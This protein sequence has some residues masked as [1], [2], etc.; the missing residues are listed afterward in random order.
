MANKVWVFD[1]D[2]TGMNTL[3]LYRKP[4]ENA[5]SLMIEVLGNKAPSEHEIRLR[6]NKLDREMIY[7]INPKNGKPFFYAKNRFPTSLVRIYKILCKEAGVKVDRK[8]ASKIFQIGLEVFN[9]RRYLRKIKPSF[10]PLCKFLN[11][12][13]DIIIILTKGDKEVQGDKIDALKKAGILKYCKGFIIAEDAKDK[14]FEEI[15]KKYG[16]DKLYY[17]VGDTYLDDMVPALK[18][19]YFGIYIPS[20]FNWKEMGRL[21]EINRRRNKK[22]SNRYRDLSE[23]RRKYEYL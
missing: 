1:L 3:D 7:E 8:I 19:G 6:H 18:L 22:R 20:L 16:E 10:L 17:S 12:R 5:C 21:S 9:K 2:G 14:C 15:R 11:K 23:I 13:G 4:L